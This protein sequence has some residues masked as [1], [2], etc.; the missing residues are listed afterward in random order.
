VT[1]SSNPETALHWQYLLDV[2]ASFVPVFYFIFASTF[3]NKPIKKLYIY[4]SY[5]L[6][7]LLAIFSFSELFKIGVKS[8]YGFYWINP[9]SY[10]VIFPAFFI[11]Y[12]TVGVIILL[13]AYFQSGNDKSKRARAR[14]VL[15]A[16]AIAAGGGLTNFFP[17]FFSVYPFGN[18]LIIIYIFFVS[19]GVL[20]YKLFNAKLFSAQLFSAGLV[21]IFFFNLL[22][23]SSLTDWGINL[24][25]FGF[26]GVFSWFLVRS[27]SKEIE[28]RQ[29]IEILAGDLEKANTRLKEIDQL[30]SEFVSLA[31]HQIRGPLTSIKGFASLILEGDY[32]D[33][34]PTLKDPVDKIY[35]SSQALV[36]IVQDFLDVSR[37][38]Q[39]K[40][41]YDFTVF[42]LVGLVHEVVGEL[43][44]VVEK[45]GLALSFETNEKECTVKADRGKI[46]QVIS[47]L[48]DNAMKYT[49]KGTIAVSLGQKA[50]K[51]LISVKDSGVGISADTIDKLFQKFSRAKDA[52]L[53]NVAGSGLGLYVAK[54]MVVAH[55][56]RIWAES[57]GKGKG[58]TFFVE[59]DKYKIDPNTDKAPIEDNN[60]AIVYDFAKNLSV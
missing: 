48:I 28:T 10:Y 38:E 45:K 42:D 44:Q 26:S 55:K 59:L 9:G 14:S 32:G 13:R 40:M 5:V 43:T 39:G 36:G 19:Y 34:N 46:R 52:H 37:I 47:N 21:V 7:I 35:Q 29:K 20:R 50:D 12:V 15:L 1:S 18:Y 31:T 6:T 27:V 56:G 22:R 49:E 30:K 51:Y 57:I 11:F 2:S 16:G 60:H 41:V 53:T 23:P 25:M 17:Q 8:I 3:L 24:L 54:E 4:I 58:S 33:V